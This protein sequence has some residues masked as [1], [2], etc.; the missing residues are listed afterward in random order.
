MFKRVVYLSAVVVA[1]AASG[2][3]GGSSTDGGETIS[4][5]QFLKMA[6]AVCSKAID[7]QTATFQRLVSKARSEEAPNLAQVRKEAT[8]QMLSIAGSL[9]D[10]LESLGLPEGEE[11]KVKALLAEYRTALASAEADPALFFT[12]KA[13]GEADD[14]AAGYGLFKCGL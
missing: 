14:A 11:E 5:H 1:V 13:F 4:K 10:D 7:E 12:G 2:C 3:G 6:N 8:D 9:L